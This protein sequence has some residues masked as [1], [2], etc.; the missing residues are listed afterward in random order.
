MLE[1]A[2]MGQRYFRRN[3]EGL[4]STLRSVGPSDRNVSESVLCRCR[5]GRCE[6]CQETLRRL[7]VL[8]QST[9]PLGSNRRFPRHGSGAGPRHQRWKVLARC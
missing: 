1:K 4:I 3:V 2:V 8:A 7:L 9:A 6:E 5:G